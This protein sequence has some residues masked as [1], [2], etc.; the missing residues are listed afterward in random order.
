MPRAHSCREQKPGR[1]G[2]TV[3]DTDPPQ[4]G[5]TVAKNGT[6]TFFVR[7]LRPTGVPKTI[8]GT[9]DE[10]TAA[11]AGKKAVAATAAA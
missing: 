3:I 1:S 11:E 6:K 7:T 10:A 2:L 9:A 5:L 8:L 4:F